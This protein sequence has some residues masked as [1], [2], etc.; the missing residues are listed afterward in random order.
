MFQANTRLPTK[1]MTQSFLILLPQEVLLINMSQPVKSLT[2]PMDNRDAEVSE[3]SN[4]KTMALVTSENSPC[5][6]A[7]LGGS[8]DLEEI[9]PNVT[10]KML[11]FPHGE[12]GAS[13]MTA[14]K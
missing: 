7:F 6:L 2:Y 11:S 3:W 9:K 13:A 5:R 4:W 8:T 14:H 1:A 12:N 10:W